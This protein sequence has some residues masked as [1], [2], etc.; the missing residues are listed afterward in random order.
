MNRVNRNIVANFA[1]TAWASILSI[2]LIPLY[3]HLMGV[4]AYGLVGLLPTLQALFV[5]LD[6]GLSTTLNRELAVASADV[7]SRRAAIHIVRTIEIVYW[8]AAI[9][10]G[11]AVTLGAP[12]LATHWV[13]PAALTEQTV[14][15]AFVLIGIS[16]MFQLPTSLYS[17]GLLGLQE[18]V[19]LNVI[20]VVAA[21]IRGVGAVGALY[22]IAPTVVVFFAWQ[23]IVTAAQTLA[24]AIA[25][26]HSLSGSSEARFRR[27]EL[28]RVRNFTLSMVMIS[29]LSVLMMHLDK[30]ILSKV[31]P[32]EQFGYYALAASVAAVMYRAFS[33]VYQAIF[34]RLSQLAST[35]ATSAIRTVYHEAAQLV[36]VL[37]IPAAVVIALFSREALLLWLRD[38]TVATRASATLSILV[39]GTAMYSTYH[40]PYALQLAYGW[41]S[42]PLYTNIAAVI[43]LAPTMFV[44]AKFY[45][46]VGAASVWVALN[47][48]YLTIPVQIMHRRLIPGAQWRWYGEDIGRPLM[49][50]ILVGV[51]G[52]VLMSALPSAVPRIAILATTA[53]VSLGAAALSV[54]V[55]ARWIRLIPR[56]L[57]VRDA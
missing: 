55:T 20:N 11:L 13:K 54:P 35:N 24:T 27:S 22:L 34:P 57:G 25:L 15:R 16:L 12:Y 37:V 21:T 39:I 23:A 45:G 10:F 36:S 32:L 1:S 31:L 18:Q 41:T 9:L 40:I 19:R 14:S 47:V 51:T 42:L 3:V 48:V 30:I 8:T 56:R 50:A 49:W 2:A 46:G 4:E 7:N 5:P 6:L 53:I 33:P 29:L 52:R 17:G 44:A 26:W 43:V 28:R 38:P